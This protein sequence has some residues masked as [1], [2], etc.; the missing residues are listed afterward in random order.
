MFLVIDEH[1]RAESLGNV[2]DVTSTDRETA[3]FHRSG[4]GEKIP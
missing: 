1:G 2:D 4:V 3:V